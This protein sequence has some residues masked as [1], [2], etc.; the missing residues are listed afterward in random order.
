MNNLNIEERNALYSL[1]SNA[2]LTMKKADNGSAVVL[3]DTDNYIQEAERQ[4]GDTN[5]Y[6]K[7]ESYMTEQHILKIG[8]I[9]KEIFDKLE[10]DIDT[11]VHLLPEMSKNR[12]AKFY[13]LP[14]IHKKEVNGRPII[15]GNGCPT[16]K[17]L[18]FRR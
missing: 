8:N 9:L 14:K 18:S 16:E 11:N 10:I 5:F 7:T 6:V 17:N 1:Q 15:S 12:T 2:D 4:L 13:F 3:M